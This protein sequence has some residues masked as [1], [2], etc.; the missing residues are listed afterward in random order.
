MVLLY[1]ET[2]WRIRACTIKGFIEGARL[3]F[4]AI[5]FDSRL[6]PVFTQASLMQTEASSALACFSPARCGLPGY[7]CYPMAP[8]ASGSRWSSIP[9]LNICE[10]TKDLACSKLLWFSNE[11]YIFANKN[12]IDS[13]LYPFNI[14]QLQVV[15]TLNSSLPATYSDISSMRFFQNLFEILRCGAITNRVFFAHG[16]LRRNNIVFRLWYMIQFTYAVLGYI[17]CS[18]YI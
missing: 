14:T 16:M 15:Y 4:L 11:K 9:V 5:S 18:S 2:C 3:F 1:R 13:N 8:Q 12:E 7:K 6:M 10:A 17:F